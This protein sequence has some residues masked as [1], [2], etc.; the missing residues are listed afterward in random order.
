MKLKWDKKLH[1]G[2]FFSSGFKN[3]TFTKQILTFN[4]FKFCEKKILI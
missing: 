3:Y 4:N 1:S 2:N